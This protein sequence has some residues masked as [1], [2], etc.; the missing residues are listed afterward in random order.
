MRDAEGLE[1]VEAERGYRLAGERAWRLGE[2]LALRDRDGGPREF[3][4]LLSKLRARKWSAE[5]P[6]RR[7]EL[8][9]KYNRTAK[10]RAKRLEHD[11]LVR[12]R[13]W[14]MA[15]AARACACC[16]VRFC[17]ISQSRDRGD[18]VRFCTPRCRRRALYLKAHPNARQYKPLRAR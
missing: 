5:N 18:G 17:P 1:R 2:W 12:R 4:R 8:R 10:G 3:R 9:R 11:R 14:T 6:E 13:R 15:R 7:R 16:G